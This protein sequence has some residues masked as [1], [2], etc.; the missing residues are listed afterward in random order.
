[1]NK[2]T[3]LAFAASD[4][5]LILGGTGFFG[6]QVL[7]RLYNLPLNKRPKVTVV[8][9][10]KIESLRKFPLLSTFAD[11]IET[12]FL[13]KSSIDIDISPTHILHMAN[14]SAH[15]TFANT[16]QYSKYL[17]LL[18]SALA[19]RQLL[20]R[21]GVRRVLFTSS[22][23]AY[24]YPS[25]FLEGSQ[26]NISL[27]TPA[28][29]LAFGKLTA[30]FILRQSALEYD[31]QLCIA[32]C[33]S[34]VG[35]DLPADIHYAIANF[36][37]DAQ[38]NRDIIIRSDGKDKRS[39]QNIKDTIDWLSHLL[40][41]KKVP[42]LIN[43]GSDEALTIIELAQKIKSTLGSKSNIIIKGEPSPSDNFKRS[44]YIPNLALAYSLG[45]TNTVSLEK[46]IIALAASISKKLRYENI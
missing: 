15:D 43:I 4:H 41:A 6:G 34:F 29:S 24:G 7:Q 21:G 27:C 26:S 44:N 35:E 10:S 45:L 38:A 8:T 31:T 20:S 13:S 25:D 32:R 9:R 14:T 23:V 11:I 37:A 17:V 30:E 5:L 36:T 3:K 18:N 22:G 39:Y 46:S 16:P 1:M 42:E 40:C 2:I 12:N 33:F 19:T 28:S